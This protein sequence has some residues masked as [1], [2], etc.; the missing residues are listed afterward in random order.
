MGLLIRDECVGADLG[1]G[2]AHVLHRLPGRIDG[3]SIARCPPHA[4]VA[5]SLPV[6]TAAACTHTPRATYSAVAAISSGRCSRSARSRGYTAEWAPPPTTTTRPAF[7]ATPASLERVE[8]VEQS[9]DH[10]LVRGADELG[11]F[12][13]GAETGECAGGV[14]QVGGALAVEVRE[15]HHAA[16][17]RPRTRGRVARA[18]HVSGRAAGPSCRSPSSR[19]A[20]TQAAGTDRWRRRSRR[21]R[22][23]RRTSVCPTPRR[24]SP[25]Y[26]ARSRRR[27]PAIRCPR[28]APMLSPVPGPTIASPNV[29]AAAPGASTDGVTTRSSPTR[30][31]GVVGVVGRVGTVTAAHELTGVGVAHFDLARLGGGVDSRDERH[32]STSDAATPASNASSTAPATAASPS[33]PLA[34]TGTCSASSAS[35]AS[36]PLSGSRRKSNASADSPP[37]TTSSGLRM[38]TRY[39]APRPNLWPASSST[40][41]APS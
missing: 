7:V 15:D 27:L 38:P 37:T 3:P 17:A 28:A 32:T 5:T 24:P 19:S 23:R 20:C 41:R 1:T 39:E 21:P 9:A 33:T 18:R 8:R 6:K 36:A 25:T 35:W 29:P 16:G 31:Q 2:C 13:V 22:P 11:R 4:T 26:R 34:T 12:G 30:L 40:P 14:G 10:A